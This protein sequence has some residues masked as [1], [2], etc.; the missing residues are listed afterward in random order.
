[1]EINLTLKIEELKEGETSLNY[2]SFAR[3]FDKENYR[4]NKNRERNRMF[5]ITQEEWFNRILK[6]DGYVFLNDVYQALGFPR[7][8]YGQVIGWIYDGKK[9]LEIKR[10]MSE[11]LEV[12]DVILDF[13]VDGE[14]LSKI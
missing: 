5:L 1:M 8:S 7:T 12:S 14:I 6:I 11:D 13:N 3:V 9:R 2:S 10:I 4:W